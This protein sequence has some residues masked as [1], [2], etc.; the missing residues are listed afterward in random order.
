MAREIVYYYQLY[1]F[2]IASDKPLPGLLPLEK[3]QPTDITLTLA[4]SERD[5]LPLHQDVG[6]TVSPQHKAAVGFSLWTNNQDQST[7]F[8][9][10]YFDGCNRFE[11]V[12]SPNGDQVWAFWPEQIQF[13]TITAYLL[14]PVLGA[15][16]R[17]RNISL[18]HASVIGVGTSAVAFLGPSG[19]G[20]STT[21]AIMSKHGFPVLTDDIAALDEQH[22][23]FWVRPGYPR[24]R[25][26]PH[27]ITT[28]QKSSDELAPVTVYND[29]RYLDLVTD[30][31]GALSF[32]SQPLALGAVYFLEARQPQHCAPSVTPLRKSEAVLAL[33]ANTYA[34]HMVQP[35]L[36][37]REL[38][39]LSRLAS[40][41][42]VKRLHRPDD[43]QA[44]T[45]VRSLLVDD[46]RNC[47]GAAG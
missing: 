13:H 34:D 10:R 8:S 33:L 28:L 6:W 26:Q 7:F 20:K 31:D 24:L 47:L 11:F 21:A 12:L 15:V 22:G 18:L 37:A 41:L 36:R 1:G 5:I 2:Q 42:P 4:G 40:R 17:L 29:K 25:L 44:L 35:G 46:F 27:V 9:L 32:Q 16:L 39:R 19:A 3:I 23:T 43:L 38:Q 14:G 30:R 45:E